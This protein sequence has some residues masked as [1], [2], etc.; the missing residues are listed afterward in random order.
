M[1]YRESLFPT[2]QR[3]GNESK[4]KIVKEPVVVAAVMRLLDCIQI[5]IIFSFVD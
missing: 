5:K 2:D 3:T 1:T 4:F